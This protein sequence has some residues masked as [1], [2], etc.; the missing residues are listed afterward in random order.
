MLTAFWDPW[1]KEEMVNGKQKQTDK[2]KKEIAGAA[3]GKRLSGGLL[4]PCTTHIPKDRE[5]IQLAPYGVRGFEAVFRF[6]LCIM[7]RL[8][9]SA[10]VSAFTCLF[11]SQF[12]AA[13]K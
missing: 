12:T 13:L 3:E 11:V 8:N 2:H 10:P 5:Q 6:K 1:K 9:Q 7:G 4:I